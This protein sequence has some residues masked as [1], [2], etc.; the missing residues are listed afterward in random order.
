[1]N[2]FWSENGTTCEINSEIER[3]DGKR[4]TTYRLTVGGY[5]RAKFYTL[6]EVCY[7]LNDSLLNGRLPQ[8]DGE[9]VRKWYNRLRWE[10]G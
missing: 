5:R 6:F 1:M 3:I 9:T 10:L 8:N 4:R 7:Y 2:L